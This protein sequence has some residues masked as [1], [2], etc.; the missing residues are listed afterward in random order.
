MKQLFLMG[1]FVLLAS[2]V[3]AQQ[4]TYT[5]TVSDEAGKSMTGATISVKNAKTK[6]QTASNGTFSIGAEKG[7]I[8]EISFS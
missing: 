2:V 5:G 8:I 6:T 7:A 4:K 3:F 1:A